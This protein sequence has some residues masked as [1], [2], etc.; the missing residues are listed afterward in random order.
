[1][2]YVQFSETY[3]KNHPVKILLD[4]LIEAKKRGV[5]IKIILD[6]SDKKYKSESDKNKNADNVIN[7]LKSYAIKVYADNS[8]TE[9][10]DK[11]VI[12]DDDMVLIGAHNWSYSSFFFNEELSVAIKCN[13]DNSEFKNYFFEILNNIKPTEK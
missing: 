3:K 7:Y 1:M 8:N 11:L 5:D 13:P 6:K 4:K 9:I 10:H 2:Y 12:V